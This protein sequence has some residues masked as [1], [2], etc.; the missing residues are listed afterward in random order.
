VSIL[1]GARAALLVF[2]AT[3]VASLGVPL[4]TSNDG[5]QEAGLVLGFLSSIGVVLAS[6]IAVVTQLAIL[7]TRLIR[8]SGR[9]SAHG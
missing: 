9:K 2:I 1:H 6:L 4:L 3:Y 8:R 7:L 5:L